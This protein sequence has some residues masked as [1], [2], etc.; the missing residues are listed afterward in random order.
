[1]SMAG[2]YTEECLFTGLDSRAYA[3]LCTQTA[4]YIANAEINGISDANG[5]VMTADEDILAV[6]TTPLTYLD[7]NSYSNI[8]V[9]DDTP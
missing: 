9:Y 4:R 2:Y 5:S 3:R 1:M 8:V 6:A 7:E